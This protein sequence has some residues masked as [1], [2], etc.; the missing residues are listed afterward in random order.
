MLGPQHTPRNEVYKRMNLVIYK[1]SV[2]SCNG[3]S[4]HEF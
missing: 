3:L 4:I 2:V 1:Y